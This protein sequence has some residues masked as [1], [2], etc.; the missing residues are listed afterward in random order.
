MNKKPKMVT[1]LRIGITASLILA[2]LQI[3]LL[4]VTNQRRAATEQ[5]EADRLVLEEN[6]AELEKVNL[7]QVAELQTELDQINQEVNELIT[8]F[9]ELGSPFA[10]YRRAL[11]L[12]DRSQVDLRSISRI[13]SAIQ[14]TRSGS[15]LF[16]EYDI[17]LGGT[18]LNC[19]QF[20]EEIELAAL[21]TVVMRSANFRIE[22]RL[23]SLEI[24]TLGIPS[25]QLD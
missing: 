6:Y 22:E 20:I 24:K 1:G 23:C 17:E 13:N 10:I 5:L 15:I 14:E 7:E 9:P 11:E 18:L 4:G 21:N 12:A 8:S 2:A 19:I 25:D 16:D 3:I